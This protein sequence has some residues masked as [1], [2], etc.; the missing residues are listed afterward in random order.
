MLV[1]RNHPKKIYGLSRLDS[2]STAI[3]LTF[4][5]MISLKFPVEG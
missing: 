4:I 2:C 3:F 1:R 5:F